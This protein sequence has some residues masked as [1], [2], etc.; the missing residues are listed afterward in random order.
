MGSL[1]N[2]SKDNMNVHLL[3][4]SSNLAE[5]YIYDELRKVCGGT[6]DSVFTINTVSAFKNMLDLVNIQPYLANRWLFILEYGKLK[7]SLKGYYGIFNADSSCFLVKVSS[8]AEFKE[9]KE[10]YD[11]VNDMYLSFI[12]YREVNF[13]LNG[14]GLSQTLIDFSAKS[15]GREPDKIFLLRNEIVNGYK[16]DSRKDIISICGTSSS[17]VVYY[18]LRLLTAKE[19]GITNEKYKNIV[20]VGIDLSE[21]Y[22]INKLRNFM[23]A[24]LKDIITIKQMYLNGVIYNS[25]TNIPDNLDEKRLSRYGHQLE[26]IKGISLNGMV[27]LLSSLTDSGYWNKDIDMLEFLY[28]FY[29]G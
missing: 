24:S 16:V 29:Y 18:V 11:R 26:F 5:I 19:T 1:F 9:F 6:L 20:K 8:Y 10:N 23:V 2:L 3:Y 17:T 25:I 27:N 13:L 22:G 12:R 14:L 7:K 4:T 15:Y 21:A 28:Q